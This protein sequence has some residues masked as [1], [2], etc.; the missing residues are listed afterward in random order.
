MQSNDSLA[1][2]LV[3]DAEEKIQTLSFNEEIF[4]DNGLLKYFKLDDWYDGYINYNVEDKIL[5]SSDDL[6]F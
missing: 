3:R 2:K 5:V 6:P 4:D 1:L